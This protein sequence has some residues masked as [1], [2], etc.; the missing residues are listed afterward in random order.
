MAENVPL[1]AGSNVI[2][3]VGSDQVG[4]I[5]QR[6]AVAFDSL[7]AKGLTVLGQ[8][9]SGVMGTVLPVALRVALKNADG[10]AV[11]GE[12]VILKWWTTTDCSTGCAVGGGCDGRRREADVNFRLGTWA[13]SGNNRV[14]VSAVGSRRG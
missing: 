9:Q 5:A 12:T 3:A 1:V 4:N 13:G 11:A 7:P 8:Q 14:E 6:V 10:T 2:T